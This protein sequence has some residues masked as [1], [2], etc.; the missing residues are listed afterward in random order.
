MTVPV[1][2]MGSRVRA[3]ALALVRACGSCSSA[4]MEASARRFATPKLSGSRDELCFREHTN[5]WAFEA[6]SLPTG[7]P[8]IWRRRRQKRRGRACRGRC[9]RSRKRR[10]VVRK[11]DMYKLLPCFLRNRDPAS[12]MR[13]GWAWRSSRANRVNAPRLWRRDARSLTLNTTLR[14]YRFGSFCVTEAGRYGEA[15]GEDSENKLTR[16]RY[17]GGLSFPHLQPFDATSDHWQAAQRRADAHQPKPPPP[18]PTVTPRL[19]HFK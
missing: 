4:A 9:L 5:A 8:C 18:K 13:Q 11:R 3:Q 2:R 17:H 19:P 1:T 7:K 10:S 14:V 12:C 15:G 6:L 16:A